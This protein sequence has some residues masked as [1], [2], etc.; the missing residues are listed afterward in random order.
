MADYVLIV[1]DDR[2]LAV[3]ICMAL[4]GSGYECGIARNGREALDWVAK[5]M[6]SLIVLDMLMP[7][8]DGWQFAREFHATY[9]A[10]A[11]ILVLTAA[12]RGRLRGPQIDAAAVLSKPFD[13][14]QLIDTI[15]ELIARHA[16][17]S[18]ANQQHL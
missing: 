3:A 2:N 1:E 12:E 15:G 17:A 5:R 9:G 13:V 7:I 8:M 11:P 16:T 4:E 14:G 18:T 10:T 6:P